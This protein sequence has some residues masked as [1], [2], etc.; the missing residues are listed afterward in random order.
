MKI[1]KIIAMCILIC[2]F[3]FGQG[4]Y[5]FQKYFIQ[6]NVGDWIQFGQINYI[7][8]G[9]FVNV[10]AWAH[11]GSQLFYEEFEFAATTYGNVNLEWVE[12]APKLTN[13][14]D[15][16]QN[17][18]LDAR[19]KCNNSC[20][21]ELRLRRLHGGGVPGEIDFIVESNS[22][23]S[24]LN[25]Q[26]TAGAVSA[27]YL[28]NNGGY[29]FPVSNITFGASQEGLFINAT[30]NVSIGTTNATSKLAVNGNIRAKEIKV[31]NTNW[32]DFVFAKS[33]VLPTLQETEQHINEKGHLPGIPSATEVK[34]NGV[35]LGEMNAKLLQKIEELTL[36]ILEQNK[37]IQK[38]EFNQKANSQ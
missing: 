18:A 13:G 4:K 38:L 21:L 29:K 30:G 20:V 32:P 6:P 14:Y 2:Q 15:G 7:P 27:G 10:K 23:F 24:E 19:Y 5:T 12:I 17:F 3:S 22:I 33:Y 8:K 1:L 37:R 35:D 31:E 16:H 28:G 34:A 25:L 26:G 36:H 11:Y 9:A